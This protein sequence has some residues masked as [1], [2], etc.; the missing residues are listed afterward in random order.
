MD[1]TNYFSHEDIPSGKPV[2]MELPR[3]FKSDGVQYD[4]VLRLNKSLYGQ[5]EATWLW[6]EKLQ[7]GLLDRGFVVSKVDPCVFMSKTIIYVVYVYYCLF[8]ARS[9]SNIDHST[10]YFKKYGTNYSW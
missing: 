9:K 5:D 6:Y 8:W 3:Y 4:V 2:F 1:F 10:K 7:N